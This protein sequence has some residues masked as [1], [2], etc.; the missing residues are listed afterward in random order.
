[1]N[2]KETML[3]TIVGMAI[4]TTVTTMSS[5]TQALAL[6]HWNTDEDYIPNNGFVEDSMDSSGT[7]DNSNGDDEDNDEDSTT[8]TDE[9]D[10]EDNNDDSSEKEDSSNV[11]DLQACLSDAEGPEGDGSPTEEQVQDC[12][13]ASNEPASTESTD[14]DGDEDEDSVTEHVSTDD[15]E[16]EE[17]ED[18]EDSEE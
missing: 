14:D 2:R 1:M 4:L 11:A 17:D 7:S 8:A 12:E 10:E 5:S 9:D 13:S 6:G 3:M 18:S 15:S 16:D